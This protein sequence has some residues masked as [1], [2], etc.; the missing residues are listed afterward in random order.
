MPLDA[1]KWITHVPVEVEPSYDGIGVE[2][3][4]AGVPLR[5]IGLCRYDAGG[6]AQ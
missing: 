6:Q 4:A 5:K 3:T 1:T 2:V